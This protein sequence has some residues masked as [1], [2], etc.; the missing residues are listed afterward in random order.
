MFGSRKNLMSRRDE[1]ELLK[2]GR[3][4]FAEQFPNPGFQLTLQAHNLAD[5]RLPEEAFDLA[6]G[7]LLFEHL[8]FVEPDSVVAQARGV[9]LELQR[10][11]TEQLTSGKALS[12][13]HFR[14]REGPGTSVTAEPEEGTSCAS[15]NASVAPISRVTTSTM[16]AT[17]FRP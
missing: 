11:W 17:S 5:C 13:L 1:Q 8:E 3:G 9:R 6:H 14:K 7:A 15:T 12:V 10:Q 2:L 4:L 16:T